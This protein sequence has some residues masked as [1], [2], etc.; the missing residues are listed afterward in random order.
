MLFANS[1]L[2]QQLSAVL[3]IRRGKRDNIGINR[4]IDGVEAE[5]RKSQASFQII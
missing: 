4:N 5:A 2:L 1:T 3:Q